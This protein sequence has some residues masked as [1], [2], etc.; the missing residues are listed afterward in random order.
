MIM[1]NSQMSKE[2][3]KNSVRM[4]EYIFLINIPLFFLSIVRIYMVKVIESV[5]LFI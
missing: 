3:G 4:F 2:S 1:F 5:H